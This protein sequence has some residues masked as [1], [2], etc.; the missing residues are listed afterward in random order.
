[1]LGKT[2]KFKPLDSGIQKSRSAEPHVATDHRDCRKTSYQPFKF[3]GGH[4][5]Q[6]TRVLA[7]IPW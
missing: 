6:G 5:A 4:G 2:P 1:M 3:F 7:V